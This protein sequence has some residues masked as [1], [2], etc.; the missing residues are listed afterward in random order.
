MLRR[1]LLDLSFP[2]ARVSTNENTQ[3]AFL[4]AVFRPPLLFQF[5]HIS[6]IQERSVGESVD[7]LNPIADHVELVNTVINVLQIRVHVRPGHVR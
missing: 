6:L 7:A 3:M 2:K 1:L 4:P 5:L